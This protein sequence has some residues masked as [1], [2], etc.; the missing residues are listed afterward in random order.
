MPD[1]YAASHRS[2]WTIATSFLPR[3]NVR[4]LSGSTSKPSA[5]VNVWTSAAGSRSVLWKRTWTVVTLTPLDGGR[6]LV[7]GASLGYGTDPESQAM[8]RFF[9]RGNDETIKTLAARFAR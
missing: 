6:T 8:R 3:V 1:R 2:G 7:R 5:S 4:V 9:E